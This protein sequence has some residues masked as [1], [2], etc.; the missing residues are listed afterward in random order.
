[1]VATPTNCFIKLQRQT[2]LS[3]VS[4]KDLD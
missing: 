3:M 2:S 4:S 1:M